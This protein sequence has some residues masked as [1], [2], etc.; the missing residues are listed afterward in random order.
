LPPPTSCAGA[1][2]IVKAVKM[3]AAGN[4]CWLCINPPG[5]GHDLSDS[6]VT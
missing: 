4:I 2:V 6:T 3:A 5:G 1:T